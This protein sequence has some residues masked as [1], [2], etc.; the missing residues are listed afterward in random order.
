[1][2]HLQIYSG[3]PWLLASH[4]ENSQPPHGKHVTS[5]PERP[6]LLV[7]LLRLTGES[8]AAT[9]LQPSPPEQWT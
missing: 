5:K 1:M 6:G 2:R 3:M 8:E 7:N 4:P 9:P